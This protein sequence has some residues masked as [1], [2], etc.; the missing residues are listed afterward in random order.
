MRESRYNVWVEH[1]DFFLVFNA[2]SG[3]A[4]RVPRISLPDVQAFICGSDIACDFAVLRDMT[5]ARMLVP[6]SLDELD[7]LRDRYLRARRGDGVLGLTL[8]TSLGCNFDC[9]YCFEAKHPSLMNS[10]VQEGILRYV[11]QKA[12]TIEALSVTWFGGEPLL[13]KRAILDLSRAFERICSEYRL[14]YE[15]S[16]I[17]NGYLLDRETAQQLSESGVR[18]AQI[19]LDGPP[20]VH[21]LMRPLRNGN[22]TF[23]TI[24]E[25][26][27]EAVKFLS[28]AVRVNLAQSN[29]RDYF[30][31][32]DI[33]HDAGLAGRIAVTP[34]Q[35]VLDPTGNG[36]AASCTMQA[37]SLPEFAELECEFNE[38]ARSRGFRVASSMSPVGVPCTAARDDDL[39]VGSAGE[40]YKC[41][42]S[43]GNPEEVIGNIRTANI[44]ASGTKWA[45]YGP[46]SDADCTQCVALPVCMGGCAHH[47]MS[48]G[49]RDNRCSTFRYEH[50]EQVRAVAREV[51]RRDVSGLIDAAMYQDLFSSAK[52]GPVLV[53]LGKTRLIGSDPD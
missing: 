30:R 22:R 29:S 43:V 9:P 47:A 13:G 28:V 19:T 52:S 11:A 46:F 50:R 31:L 16:I 37:M 41:L 33:L 8:V 42:D 10:E 25:N 21:D 3:M 12:P 6:D 18:S 48:P 34:G 45:E 49:N 5:M 38:Y 53:S 17:T 40:L 7:L 44:N 2:V 27:C 36:P 23:A 26:L 15:A 51:A 24:L 35:I 14:T 39:V 1:Q 20:E 4:V 32:L